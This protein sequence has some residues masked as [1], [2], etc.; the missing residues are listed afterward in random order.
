MTSSSSPPLRQCRASPEIQ[1]NQE[2]RLYS[3]RGVAYEHG[4]LG[5]ACNAD[6]V[7]KTRQQQQEVEED[8]EDKDNNEETSSESEHPPSLQGTSV[9]ECKP[10]G[11]NG[12]M[13]GMEP[14]DPPQVDVALLDWK[15]D[16]VAPVQRAHQRLPNRDPLPVT[17]H[18]EAVCDSHSDDEL[19][20]TES[21]DDDDDKEPRPV[22]RKRPF[23][24]HDG[25]MQKKR[26]Y[27]TK[28]KGYCC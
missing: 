14:I 9:G 8:E 10:L 17:G 26:K 7:D 12:V 1:L 22:K 16:F 23:L 21:D 27:S 25:P 24:C 18:D 5:P 28:L 13:L 6:P 19:N 2:G 3:G 15:A 20:N 4:L 11:G